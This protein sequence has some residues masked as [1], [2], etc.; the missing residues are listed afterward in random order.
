MKRHIL[1]KFVID[2]FIP[3]IED[4]KVKLWSVDNG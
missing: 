1:I 3:A 2:Q 4:K